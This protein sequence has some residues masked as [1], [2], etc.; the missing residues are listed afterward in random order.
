M[1]L[2][3]I[4][5]IPDFTRP[6][7]GLLCGLKGATI[8]R[9]KWAGPPGAVQPEY[10]AIYSPEWIFEMDAINP[11]TGTGKSGRFVPI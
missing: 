8:Y 3:S 7:M 4:V 9:Q 1:P 6:V 5:H 10:M 2:Y 11:Y